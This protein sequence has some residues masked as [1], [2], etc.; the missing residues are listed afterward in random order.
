MPFTAATQTI[1]SV[2]TD[3]GR[4]IFARSLLG[5]LSFQL[6]GFKVGRAGYQLGMPVWVEPPNTASVQLQ[7]QIHPIGAG[8]APLI[9][10]EQPYPN[11]IA[12]VCRLNRNDAQ[13]GIGEIGLYVRVVRTGTFA[14]YQ[15]TNGSGGILFLAKASGTAGNAVSF[16]LVNGGA[17]Q[18]LTI[19][20]TGNNVTI[21]LATDGSSVVTSTMAQVA[22]AVTADISANQILAAAPTG[23]PTA[24][25]GTIGTTFLAGGTNPVLPYV[26]GNDYLLALAHTP[27]ISKTDKTVLVFRFV[28]AT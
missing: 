21:N 14:Q 24:L 23:I 15:Y 6:S 9:T 18:P 17:N 16:S 22:A 5:Q 27:L 12:A 7:D 10:I 28:V 2:L 4:D 3:Q 11:V 8:V 19:V 1:Q 13:Y 26:V 25:V 20:T